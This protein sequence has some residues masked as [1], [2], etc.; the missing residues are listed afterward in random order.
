VTLYRE[1]STDR[2]WTENELMASLALEIQGLD[3]EDSF[4]QEVDERG[5]AAIHEFVIE[6]ESVGIYQRVD[7][8]EDVAYRRTVDGPVFYA[9]STRLVSA[10]A[11]SCRRAGTTW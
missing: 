3:G 11:P 9:A 8:G 4:K 5:G 6:C 2:I 10:S 7:D 1:T